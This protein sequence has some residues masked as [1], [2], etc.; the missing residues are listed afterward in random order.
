MKVYPAANS[1]SQGSCEITVR[2]LWA[3]H[4]LSPSSSAFPPSITVVTLAQ[5]RPKELTRFT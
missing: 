3:S 5:P 4:S 1:E 2:L